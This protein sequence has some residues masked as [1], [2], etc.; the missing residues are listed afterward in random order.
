MAELAKSLTRSANPSTS[1]ISEFEMI[2]RLSRRS[3]LSASLTK[4]STASRSIASAKASQAELIKP[5]AAA[6]D[7]DCVACPISGKAL[8]PAST[9]VSVNRT[10]RR[11]WLKDIDPPGRAIT[12]TSPNSG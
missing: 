2:P 9:K 6:L 4:S 8:S 12:C 10:M 11:V 5:S 7:C 3:P 1:A